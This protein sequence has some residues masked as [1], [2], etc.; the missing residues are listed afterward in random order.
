MNIFYL[1]EKKTQ[2]KNRVIFNAILHFF[3]NFYIF[4]HMGCCNFVKNKDIA[5]M[6]FLFFSYEILK[7]KIFYKF[8]L[9]FL[10]D[11]CKKKEKDGKVVT[12]LE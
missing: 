2:F 11:S 1:K 7:I 6:F 12:K 9:Q 8:F 5:K 4:K 10:I 3:A